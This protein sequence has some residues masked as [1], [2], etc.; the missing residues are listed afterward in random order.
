M[1][2]N[3]NIKSIIGSIFSSKGKLS[4]GFNAYTVEQVWRS[5]FGEVISRYTSGVRFSNGK[6]IVYITSSPLK[7][8]L[9]MTKEKV[10]TKMNAQLKYHKV[11]EL[12][13]R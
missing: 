6:L 2:D 1:S 11:T 8:E 4:K 7:Q 13:I 10:I 9:S 3:Q 12:I 5:T